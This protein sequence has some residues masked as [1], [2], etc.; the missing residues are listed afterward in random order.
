MDYEYI[1]HMILLLFAFLLELRNEL[2]LVGSVEQLLVGLRDLLERCLDHGLSLRVGDLSFLD[3]AGELLSSLA[4][5]FR[6]V[7]DDEA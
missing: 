6:V 7:N 1:V 4:K 2:S 5:E 3:P